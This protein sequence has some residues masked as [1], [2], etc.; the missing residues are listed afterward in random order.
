MLLHVAT[1]HLYAGS[2][3]AYIISTPAYVIRT[4]SYV[5]KICKQNKTKSRA[6]VATRQAYLQFFYFLIRR[7]H[8]TIASEVSDTT[9]RRAAHRKQFKVR[10]EGPSC[11]RPF[12]KLLMQNDLYGKNKG[13]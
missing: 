12:K 7:Q 6:Y 13:S 5:A 2:T 4:P 9:F 11:L 10:V 8:I 3:P 1:R